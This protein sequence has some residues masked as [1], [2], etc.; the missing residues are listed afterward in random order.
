MNV[1]GSAY[2]IFVIAF[3]VFVALFVA[4]NLRGR[5]PS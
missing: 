3:L 2:P 5:R 4:V 1:P